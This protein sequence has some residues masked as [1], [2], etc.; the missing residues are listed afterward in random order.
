MLAVMSGLVYSGSL[1]FGNLIDSTMAT[2]SFA[3]MMLGTVVV[4]ISFLGTCGSIMENYCLL[5]LFSLV[6][7][8]CFLTEVLSLSFIAYYDARV[9]HLSFKTFHSYIEHYHNSTYH[10]TFV[11]KIQVTLGC[12]GASGPQDFYQSSY[13]VGL[14][15]SETSINSTVEVMSSVPASCCLNQTTPCLDNFNTTCPQAISHYFEE[16]LGILYTVCCLLLLI[17]VLPMMFAWMQANSTRVAYYRF[18]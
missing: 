6:V 11:D 13:Q 3:L 16:N 7:G 4:F 1:M 2:P 12:C 18:V 8:V 14:S 5:R 9:E 17:Q 10:R 15:T